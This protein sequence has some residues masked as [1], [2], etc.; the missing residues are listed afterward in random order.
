MVFSG[1]AMVNPL[2]AKKRLGLLNGVPLESASSI[3]CLFLISHFLT[4]LFI[5]TAL[6]LLFVDFTFRR[7][8]CWGQGDAVIAVRFASNPWCMGVAYVFIV[9]TTLR[10]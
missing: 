4:P 5:P 6:H 7:C 1:E 9:W 3:R 10:R 8:R 2:Q